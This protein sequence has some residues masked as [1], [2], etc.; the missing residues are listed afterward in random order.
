M[1]SIP[2]HAPPHDVFGWVIVACGA[3]ATLAVI[4]LALFWT[5][6]PGETDPGHPKR[7]VLRSD[8]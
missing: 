6:R 3:A 5:I 7:L 1:N 2:M 4:V 8:R